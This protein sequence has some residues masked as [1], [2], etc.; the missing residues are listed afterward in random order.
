M[1]REIGYMSQAFSLY[2]ELTVR[3]NLQ[4]H[5]RIF[6]I[7]DRDRR[8]DELAERFGLIAQMDP[9]GHGVA[10]WHQAASFAG[11]RCDPPTSRAD[12]GRADL[13]GGP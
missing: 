11:R 4:L 5:A 13:R 8:I 3:Q 9:A 6:A 1:R 7:T 10:T 12:P 2:G